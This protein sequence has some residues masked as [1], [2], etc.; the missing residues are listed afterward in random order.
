MEDEILSYSYIT[1]IL[2]EDFH[3]IIIGEIFMGRIIKVVPEFLLSDLK[4]LLTDIHFSPL[5]YGLDLF[6]NVVIL[7][8]YIRSLVTS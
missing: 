2:S 6:R 7:V 8:L 3:F 4:I 1:Y 5:S